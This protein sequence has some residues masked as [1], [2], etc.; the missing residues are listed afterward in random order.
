MAELDDLLDSLREQRAALIEKF[1]VLSDA[2]AQSVV[3]PSGWSAL[4]MAHHVAR[5]ERYWVDAI[6]RGD[7]REVRRPGH[8][9]QLGMGDT[10][11]SLV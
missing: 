4:D 2:Q 7:D 1:E 10:R 8:H 6:M 11:R 9:R 5:V 3:V